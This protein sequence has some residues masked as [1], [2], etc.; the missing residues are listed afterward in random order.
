MEACWNHFKLNT[1]NNF[2]LGKKNLKFAKIY[3]SLEVLQRY[4]EILKI[5][6]PI[7]KFSAE[8]LHSESAEGDDMLEFKLT[9]LSVGGDCEV[10]ASTVRI[11][12][13]SD[14]HD[15]FISWMEKIQEPL[16]PSEVLFPRANLQYTAVYSRLE[17]QKLWLWFKK[18]KIDSFILQNVFFIRDKDYLFDHKDPNL[19]SPATRSR[20]V[21]FLLKRKRFSEDPD[22]DFA[23]GERTFYDFASFSSRSSH[24][25]PQV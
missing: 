14:V 25:S 9:Q 16:F 6:M 19:F 24:T 7:K 23:F 5:R 3:T 18:S 2:I 12:L 11:P 4:A 21:E 17:Y 15:G 1:L 13:F 10:G 20:I 8:M 22:D